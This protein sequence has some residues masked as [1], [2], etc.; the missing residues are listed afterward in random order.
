MNLTF[1]NNTYSTL[2][3]SHAPGATS[4]VLGSGQGAQ[5]GSTFPI[6]V[7]AIR[8]STYRTTAETLTLFTVTGISG[9]T[10][11]VSATPAESTSDPGY[12]P[13]DVVEMR[14]T[15]GEANSIVSQIN[16]LAPLASPS[17]TGTVTLPVGLTGIL[18]ASSGVVSTAVAGTDYLVPGGSG[19]ALTGLTQ[20]QISGLTAALALLAP[21]ASP[22]FTGTVTLPT[23][24]SGL[25]YLTAGVLSALGI[26]SGLSTV[27][28]NLTALGGGSASLSVVPPN[29]VYASSSGIILDGVTD[30]TSRV[31]AILD[32]AG[33]AGTPLRFVLDG[34]LFLAGTLYLWSDQ[35]FDGA[36]S[37]NS[38]I[39][40]GGYAV[41]NSLPV[42]SNKHWMLG[43]VANN[44]GQTDV[45]IKISNLYI[46]GNRRGGSAGQPYPNGGS[47]WS[48]SATTGSTNYV[49]P[50]IGFYGVDQL[51]VDNV[52]I[53]DPAA[54]GL[55][56]A[57][58]SNS[59]ITNLKKWHNPAD[60]YNGSAVFQCE[61]YCYGIQFYGIHGSNN[62]DPWAFNAD[63]GQEKSP[64]INTFYPGTCAPGG[65]PI[66]YC[67]FIGGKFSQGGGAHL[68]SGRFCSANTSS[69]ILGVTVSDVEIIGAVDGIIF[70]NLG[71]TA[72]SGSYDNIT[73][74]NMRIE[75]AAANPAIDIKAATI[76]NLVIDN[77]TV[78]QT[79]ANTTAAASCISAASTSTIS[80]LRVNGLDYEDPSGNSNV[81]VV[82]FAGTVTHASFRD[83]RVNRGTTNLAKPF[84]NIPSGTTT[85][86]QIEGG[87]F[88]HLANIVLVDGGT[89]TTCVANT[90]IH[91]NS[92]SN[93]SFAQTSGTFSLLNYSAISTA[94]ITSGTI[95]TVTH[96]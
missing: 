81:P 64:V 69:N 9:D 59:T 45:R 6:I 22:D 86:I 93:S 66:A 8:A 88:D 94:S 73:I 83:C 16:L 43:T 47:P 82:N 50:A 36:G 30:Q 95:V 75:M 68:T 19:A 51:S 7:T 91:T 41:T 65:G 80:S 12:D 24:L 20:S 67:S 25:G 38:T 52:T 23:G 87:W 61:G 70:D 17:F 21:L 37:A 34:P 71:I 32:T 60:T 39:T 1:I 4:L 15:A 74:R 90:A 26:G 96:G 85:N 89:L 46:D 55:H 49:V 72:G 2:A 42:I 76:N 28:G 40:K 63:D 48:S 29:I 33:A 77:L 53:Y 44:G 79:V 27:G 5:F 62:D 10:L 92:N 13:G 31:Q 35:H 58:V 78:S 11:T 56:L 57:N 3:S 84:I 54:Y 14:W 18:E